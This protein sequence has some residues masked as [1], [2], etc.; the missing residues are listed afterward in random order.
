M[1]E[2]SS[3]LLNAAALHR[4][5]HRHSDVHLADVRNVCALCVCE[6]VIRQASACCAL[7]GRLLCVCPVCM[8]DILYSV[9][10]SKL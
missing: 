7:A 10:L 3:R 9:K 6:C 1:E 8:C 4:H 5:R 2:L